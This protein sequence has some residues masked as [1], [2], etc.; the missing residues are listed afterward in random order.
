MNAV[1]FFL[2]SLTMIVLLASDAATL[3][4]QT[5]ANISVYYVLNNWKTKFQSQENK[6]NQGVF[7]LNASVTP[8]DRFKFDLSGTS[9]NTSLTPAQEP[10]S[11]F[12]SLNDTKLRGTYFV[13]GRKASASV[14][15]NLPTGKKQLTSEQYVISA[16]VSDPTLKFLTRRYGQGFDIGTDWYALPKV[17]NATIQIGGGYLYRGKYQ[18]L[19]ADTR[20]YKYGDEISGKVGV[21][22]GGDMISG[23]GSVVVKYYSEDKF[24]GQS[25]FQAGISTAISGAVYYSDVFD[26]NAGFS[27]LMRGKAKIRTGLN[28]LTDENLKSGR[29]EFVIYGGGAYPVSEKLRVLGRLEYQSVSAND[30]TVGQVGYAPKSHYIGIGGGVGYSLTEQFSASGMA[31]LYSGSVDQTTSL[32]LSGFGLAFALTYRPR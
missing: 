29:N 5:D 4:A 28:T 6:L 9:T 27:V 10:Q 12:S 31:T 14:Y 11:S 17:G 3:C 18:V 8:N 23:S 13:A 26:V 21:N 1:R 16:A 2:I 19:S 20:Q 30:L 24:D 15:V 22:V 7:G 32:D 25:V